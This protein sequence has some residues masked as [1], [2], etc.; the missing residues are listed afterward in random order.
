MNP[1]AVSS[2]LASTLF[3]ICVPVCNLVLAVRPGDFDSS[4]TVNFRDFS[5][6]A[7]AWLVRSGEPGWKAECDISGPPDDVIDILDLSVFCDN[8]LRCAPNVPPDMVLVAGGEFDMGDTSG[9]GDPDERPAHRVRVRSFYIGRYEVTN[10]QYCDFLNS[11]FSQNHIEVRDDVVY[12]VGKDYAYFETH[13][14]SLA[15]QIDY[16]GGLFTVRT[17]EGYDMADHPVIQ[18]SW[19]GAAA[20]CNWRSRE[21]GHGRCYDPNTWEFDISKTAYRLATEAE[22]EYAAKGGCHDP[23]YEYPWCDNSIDC[24]KA[25]YSV[26]NPL[27]FSSYPFTAPVGSYSADGYGLYDMAGNVWEWC[28]DWYSETYYGFSPYDDPGGPESGTHRVLRGGGWG[29][30]LFFCRVTSRYNFCDTCLEDNF[31]FRVVLSFE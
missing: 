26:C 7:D 16:S 30:H 14:A 10:Q 13:A 27:G 22:W 3:V 23:Y 24:T 9:G 19:H 6:L 8:W 18:V 28:N 20:Y 25:N 17:R 2:C 5:T 1:K 21:E 4:G 12:A 29:G 15:S 11:A 31:G